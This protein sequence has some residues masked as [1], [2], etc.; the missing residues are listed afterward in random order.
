[1][2]SA[3]FRVAVKT[4]YDFSANESSKRNFSDGWG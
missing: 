4:V 2:L 3:V 1:M